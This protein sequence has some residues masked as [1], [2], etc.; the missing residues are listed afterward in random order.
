MRVELDGV[1]TVIEKK[2]SD[3]G[4]IFGLKDYAG[5]TAKVVVMEKKKR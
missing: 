2:I 4:R 5:Y 1:K 3:D